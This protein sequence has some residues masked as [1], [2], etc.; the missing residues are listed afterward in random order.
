MADDLLVRWLLWHQI[1]AFSAAFSADRESA[2]AL[3]ASVSRGY[4]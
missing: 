1:G 2:R 4:V 3:S